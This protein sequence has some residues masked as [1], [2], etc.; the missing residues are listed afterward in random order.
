MV[1]ARSSVRIDQVAGTATFTLPGGGRRKFSLTSM[2][3]N[4]GSAIATITW[5]PGVPLV[6]FETGAGH[7]LVAELPTAADPTPTGGRPVIYLDQNHWSTLANT[8]HEPRRVPG[9]ELEA[10]RQIIDLA[11]A[12]KVILPMSWAHV[13]ETCKWTRSERR[14]RLAITILQLSRGWQMRHPLD[15]RR[16]EVRE[17]FLRYATH[18]SAPPPTFTLEPDA[19]HCGHRRGIALHPPEGFPPDLAYS[20]HALVSTSAI[21]DTMLDAE[22]VPLGDVSG[23]VEGLDRF[24]AWLASK[25]ADLGHLRRSGTKTFFLADLSTE[26]PE[27]A[28]AAGLTA[29]EMSDWTLNRSDADFA[30]MPMLGLFREVMGDKLVNATSRWEENDL[31]DLM[32]ISCAAGAADHVVTERSLGAYMRQAV[33][34]LG[35]S[36]N[37][38]AN[39]GDLSAQLGA[40]P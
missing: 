29:N 21:V 13:A 4:P 9:R 33:R 27:E 38:H 14:Y 12:R 32:Y 19:I 11:L 37:I 18:N 40:S 24:T 35:R 34:R 31:I 36:A 23:W 25:P 20:H 10:A 16:S 39:L 28:C 7:T 3:H 6:R 17:A 15:V 8:I 1:T 2:V 30:A 26:I 22:H 5:E